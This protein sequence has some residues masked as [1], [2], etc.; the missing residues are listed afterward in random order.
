M[1]HLDGYPNINKLLIVDAKLGVLYQEPSLRSGLWILSEHDRRLSEFTPECAFPVGSIRM[2]TA[3]T[4]KDEK[5]WVESATSGDVIIGPFF[6]DEL[7]PNVAIRR[8]GFYAAGRSFSCICINTQRA[9]VTSEYHLVQTSAAWSRE[10]AVQGLD[11]CL[12]LVVLLWMFLL[13]T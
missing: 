13:H 7:Q 12:P 5:R 3:T 11:C 9:E 2:S 6:H 4:N 1:S 10:Q 8:T